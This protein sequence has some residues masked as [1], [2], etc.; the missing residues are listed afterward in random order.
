MNDARVPAG[1]PRSVTKLL[2]PEPWRRFL[3]D[4]RPAAKRKKPAELI[5][6]LDELPPPT[7]TGLPGLQ[8]ASLVRIQLIYPPLVIQ[9]ADLPPATAVNLLCLAMIALGVASILQSLPR[10]PIGSGFLCPSCHTGIFLEPS[11]AAVKLGGLPLVFGM[12]IVAGLIQAVLSPVLRRIR[13]LLP[14]EIGGLVVFFVV[15]TPPAIRRPP[16]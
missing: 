14:P 6:G 13:P 1:L 4:T 10:G 2:D 15:P 7:V 3:R 16:V 8:P 5:H 9:L 12:T 11:I